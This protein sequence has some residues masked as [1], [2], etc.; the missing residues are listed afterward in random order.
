MNAINSTILHSLFMPI[1]FGTTVASAVLVI[2]SLFRRAEPGAT[3]MLA[4]GLIYVA[5]RFLCTMFFNVPLNN[6]LAAVD[7]ESG[8]AASTWARYL[9]EW[10]LWNH[11]R[12]I[13]SSRMPLRRFPDFECHARITKAVVV[14]SD[15]LLKYLAYNTAETSRPAEHY[16]MRRFTRIRPYTVG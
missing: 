11:V 5:G 8:A 6:A 16:T 7:P 15:I 3:A 9:K 10:T 4:G 1:F 14:F 2:I 12:T 13:S